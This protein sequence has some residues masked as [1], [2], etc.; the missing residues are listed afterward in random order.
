MKEGTESRTK[1]LCNAFFEAAKKAHPDY[2]FETVVLKEEDI[3]PY[4]MDDVNYRYGVMER[5]DLDDPILKWVN[6]YNTADKIV[7]G[8]PYWDMGFPSLLKIY[9]ENIFVGGLTF[10]GSEKGLVGLGRPKE[11]LYIQT[12]GGFV[13]EDDAATAY[14]RTAFGV[15]GIERFDRIAADGIDI[16]GIDAE[17][18]MNEAVKKLEAK[19]FEW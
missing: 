10:K 16:E 5:Q 18:L 4:T 15:M 7:I 19:A 17:G 14:L 2:E 6:Q 3:H 8:A 11:A 12:A 13:A 9:I 1:I